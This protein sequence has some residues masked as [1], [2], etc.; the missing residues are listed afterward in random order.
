V[1]ERSAAAS[2]SFTENRSSVFSIPVYSLLHA[3]RAPP[4]M[5]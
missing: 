3:Y 4:C 2:F 1:S 5:N